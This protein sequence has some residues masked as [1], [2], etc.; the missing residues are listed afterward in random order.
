MHGITKE[1][2]KDWNEQDAPAN[3]GKAGDDADKKPDDEIDTSRSECNA[4][5]SGYV[6]RS[7]G[8]LCM[9]ILQD[10]S[11]ELVAFNT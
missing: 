1:Y 10:F 9:R 5:D 8:P 2:Y 7:S 6:R 11:A 3:L 4:P